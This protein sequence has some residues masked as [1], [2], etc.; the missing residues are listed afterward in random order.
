M[1]C[2]ESDLGLLPKA[3]SFAAERRRCGYSLTTRP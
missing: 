1:K 3:V 2:E